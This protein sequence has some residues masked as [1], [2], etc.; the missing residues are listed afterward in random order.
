VTAPGV[1]EELDAIVDGAGEL[2]PGGPAFAVEELDLNPPQT[3]KNPAF[4][5]LSWNT[6]SQT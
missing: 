6:P 1:V 5:G 2:D 3:R 4:A